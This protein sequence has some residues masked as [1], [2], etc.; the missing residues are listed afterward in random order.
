[1][2]SL[3]QNQEYQYNQAEAKVVL[4]EKM[5]AFFQSLEQKGVHIIEKNVRIERDNE[6]WIMTADLQV[7]ELVG[8]KV[9]TVM[10][11]SQSIEADTM[12]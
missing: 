10:E 1:M 7:E 5:I 3:N 9:D 2:Y 6:G 8:V 11:D 4:S 12:E